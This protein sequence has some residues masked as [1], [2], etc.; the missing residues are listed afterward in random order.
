MAE[1][2]LSSFSDTDE[3]LRR[4]RYHDHFRHN[5]LHW[6]AFKD[7]DPKMSWTFRAEAL[8]TT[9]AIDEYHRYWSERVGESLPAILRFTFYGLTKCIDPPLEPRHV[10]DPDDATYGHLH[11]STERPR[12]KAHMELLQKLVNDGI[13]AGVAKRYPKHVL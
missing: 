13:H 12:D 2:V 7:P 1:P 10:P 4:V 8:R 5:L 6:K 11:C 3:F 9:A